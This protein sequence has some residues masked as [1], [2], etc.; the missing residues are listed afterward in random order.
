VSKDT[1]DT[2]TE[3][4]LHLPENALKGLT[5]ADGLMVETMATEPM[6]KN[7]T[8]IDVDERGRIWVTEAHNYRPG[9]NGNPVNPQGDRIMILEDTNADGKIDTAKVFYQGPE[10][11]APLG[12]C[13]LGNKILISQSPYVWAFYDDNADD[14][15]DRKEIIFQGIGGEQH[16][17]GVHSFSFGPDGKLYFSFGNEGKTLRDKNGRPVLDQDGE[18]IGP[19]KYRQ[20]MLFRC[21]PDATNVEC[22]GDNFRNN[23]EAA[24]DSYGTIWQSDNDDDGNRGVRIN[25]I[26]QRGNYG[27]TDEMT[28]AGWQANRTN[29]EDSIPVRHWHLNDPGVVPNMLQTGSGSPT[30][31]VMYEGSL[32]PQSFQNQ[33]IHCDP[34]PNVVRAYPVQKQG[35]GYTATILNLLKHEKDQWFRP[36]DICIAPDGSLIIAD[37]Y[38]P[39]VG[40]HAAG[41]QQRGRIYRVAP[42]GSKYE[43]PVFDYS[44]PGGAI[45]ALQNPNLAIRHHA[46]TSL[47]GFGDGAVPELQRLWQSSSNP[48]MRA[49]A[50]WL[51]VKMPGKENE[52]IQQA[53]KDNN[54]EIRILGIRAATQL[55]KDIPK[56]INQL[57][58]DPDAHVLR[59]CALSLHHL[60]DS[61]AA[62]LWTTLALKHDGKD[63]WF[64]EALGIGADNQWDKFFASYVAKVK[65]PLQNDAS[66]DIVW[67]ARTELAVPYIAE[68]ASEQNVDLKQRLRYFRA[69][70]FNQGPA[71]SKLLLNMI[72]KNI[73]NDTALNKLV[74][75]HM[76]LKTVRQSPAATAAMKN[77][78]ISLQGTPEYIEMVKKY[79][80]RSENPKL[81]NLAIAESQKG[82]GKNAAS[83]L[84]ELGGKNLVWNV[85]RK[86]DTAQSN[87]LLTALG[88]VGSKVSL[89]ILQTIIL[90]DKYPM[91]LRK[92]TATKIGRSWNGEEHVLE[93]LKTKKIPA[94]FIPQ[95]VESVS[96]AWRGSVR[97][98][99]AGYLPGPQGSTVKKEPTI[100]EVL[101]LTPKV[102][103]GKTIFGRNCA[104]CH[105][106][107]NEGFNF[108]PPLT[109]I[110]SKLP[111]ESQLE[112]ILNPSS[113]ISFGYEGWEVVMKDGSKLSGIIASKTETDVEL[114]LPAGNR[115]NI[116]TSDVKSMKKLKE[117]MMPDG[118]DQAMTTQELADLIEYLDQLKKKK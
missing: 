113:G 59:E 37:W 95:V 36:A 54:P 55:K 8:N 98:E 41:D 53:I 71:K 42:V 28:G 1:K 109:E 114:K 82:L 88:G 40:G 12:V 111:K 103:N 46:W 74:L 47:Q 87:R 116:K 34:G 56:V 9:I 64:L 70:D 23:Y 15:A 110:G 33:I 7:P 86:N 65:D 48:R 13:V 19:K 35:G 22:L 96:N 60:R 39:G 73:A 63:R 32:L 43:I 99:A 20:G 17:H 85:I 50:F 5:V 76:D 68:L 25:Y 90:D 75:R 61:R 72:T 10:L 84:L 97:S 78:I 24:V 80:V 57:V 115:H 118:L 94:E 18:E 79:Q 51:L 67:R 112:S 62:D 58:N 92:F 77:V 93:L 89:D 49:R 21:D 26:M 30:G 106:V 101:A 27:F 2:L 45:L 29:L 44:T 108:G 66:R 4:E 105:Q 52:I 14:K 69:F 83:L 6:L 3:Q 38:D 104:I 31:M 117:S 102:E 100:N 81:L 11:N 107:N 16:D 91:E